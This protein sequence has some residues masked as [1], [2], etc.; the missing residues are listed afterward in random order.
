[1]YNIP[2]FFNFYHIYLS[3]IYFHSICQPVGVFQTFILFYSNVCLFMMK[4]YLQLFFESCST[5]NLRFCFDMHFCSGYCLLY[6]RFNLNIN[7]VLLIFSLNALIT[8]TNNFSNEENTPFWPQ[9]ETSRSFM[10]QQNQ[11]AEEFSLQDT[12]TFSQALRNTDQN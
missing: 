12:I 2:C 11:R 1:M 3:S 10:P 9:I 4:V 7:L 8:N 6:L 5:M